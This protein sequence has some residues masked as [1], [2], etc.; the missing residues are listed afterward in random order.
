MSVRIE[1]AAGKWSA[2]SRCRIEPQKRVQKGGFDAQIAGFLLCDVD[3]CG[4]FT[5]GSTGWRGALDEQR[6]KM[7]PVGGAVRAEAFCDVRGD[8]RS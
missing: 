8:G 1:R 2:R 4:G 6:S 5:G 7:G 3:N